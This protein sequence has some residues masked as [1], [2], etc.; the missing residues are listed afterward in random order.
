[1]LQYRQYLST[2]LSLFAAAGFYQGIF[3]KLVPIPKKHFLIVNQHYLQWLQIQN[4]LKILSNHGVVLLKNTLQTYVSS[5]H[6]DH[7]ALSF[8]EIL[9]SDEFIA[10]IICHNDELSLSLLVIFYNSVF[11]YNST[12]YM[13]VKRMWIKCILRR[14]WLI[15]AN[16]IKTSEFIFKQ[17]S[18]LKLELNSSLWQLIAVNLWTPLAWPGLNGSVCPECHY[19]YLLNLLRI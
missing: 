12:R 10:A 4:F 5:F 19:T 6:V 11:W 15:S 9:I 18:Q 1:V 14:I 3:A 7:W 2:T 17:S 16:K 13:K 8:D